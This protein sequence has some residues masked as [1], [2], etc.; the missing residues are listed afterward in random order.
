MMNKL[1]TGLLVLFLLLVPGACASPVQAPAPVTVGTLIEMYTKTTMAGV[2]SNLTIS[3]DGSVVYVEEQG[4]RH[5]TQDN[6]PTRITRTGQLAEAEL[7]N[8][9]KMID[10][11]PFDAE[12]N[13]DASTEIIDTDAVSVL[14]VY[15]QGQTR[16]IT[17]DYQPLYHLSHPKI[18]E[19]LDVPEPARKLYRE[20]RYIIDNRTTQTA[21][22][23]MPVK[24]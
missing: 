4:L 5:P 24:G 10:A 7:N 13:C 3:A 14:T 21:E 1:I 19:L 9:L 15:Y 6:P 17:A 23:K 12:G 20:L 2:A 8:L 22:E 18:P 16:T 11:C